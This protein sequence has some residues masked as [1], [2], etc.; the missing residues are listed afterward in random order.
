M[1]KNDKIKMLNKKAKIAHLQ[2]Q[3]FH[4]VVHRGE[5]FFEF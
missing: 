4:Y 5:K 2:L 1:Q 3:I